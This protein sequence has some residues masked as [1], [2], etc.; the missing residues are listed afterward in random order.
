[1]MCYGCIQ[2]KWMSI[3]ASSQAILRVAIKQSLHGFVHEPWHPRLTDT[4][5]VKLQL[6]SFSAR[7]ILS[8]GI[9]TDALH[10]SRRMATPS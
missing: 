7:S 1:M 9:F 8:A 3:S 10:D 5:A 6:H 4:D 2:E